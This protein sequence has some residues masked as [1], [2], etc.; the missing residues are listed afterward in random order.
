MKAFLLTAG[1]G[2]RLRPLT[3]RAPKCL[4]PI[5]GRPLIDYWFDLFERY[6]VDEVLINLH[7]LHEQAERYLAAKSFHGVIHTF[8]EPELLGSAGTVLA[9][10]RFVDAEDCFF[11]LYGD[12]LTNAR[13]DRWLEFHRQHG[14][15]LT[16]MLYRTDRPHLKGIVELDSSGKVL[17]FEEKPAHPRSDIASAGM[18]IATPAIF[19]A[20]PKP[21]KPL[22]MG[23]DILPKLVGRIWGMMSDDVIMDIGTPDDYRIAQQ[24]ALQFVDRK[25]QIW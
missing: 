25:K 12:N 14:G 22:D 16:L 4:L 19:D 10:R 18:Y 1:L 13:L 3:D 21:T 5:A 20:F 2:T 7:H 11:I 6:G 15:N 9:N 23:F 17:S 8:Y 24:L